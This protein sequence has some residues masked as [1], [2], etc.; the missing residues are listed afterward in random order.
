MEAMA[1]GLSVFTTDVG[2][3]R[4]HFGEM[5]GLFYLSKNL[6]KDRI[7]IDSFKNTYNENLKDFIFL[8]HDSKKISNL[9]FKNIDSSFL[10]NS[11]LEKVE[12]PVYGEYI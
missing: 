7:L 2:E 3:I 9:F 6:E 8:N 12:L 11:S 10:W 5:E 1:N 4:R